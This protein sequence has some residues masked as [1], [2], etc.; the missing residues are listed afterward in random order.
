MHNKRIVAAV[1]AMRFIPMDYVCDRYHARRIVSTYIYIYILRGNFLLCHVFAM[2]SVQ[3][4]KSFWRTSE[5][6][7]GLALFSSLYS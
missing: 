5:N 2:K 4:R 7:F 3:N 6:C 1:E